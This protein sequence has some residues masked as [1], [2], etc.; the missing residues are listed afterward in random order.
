[1]VQEFGKDKI[2]IDGEIDIRQIA[3]YSY[4]LAV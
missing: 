3:K 4:R 1:M 2:Q